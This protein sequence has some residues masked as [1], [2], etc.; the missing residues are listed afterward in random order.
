MPEDFGERLARIETKIDA[1]LEGRSDHERRV[2][3]LE[4][5]RWLT[6]GGSAVIMWILNRLH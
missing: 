4:Q 2:R 3:V 1:L 6:L 5:W